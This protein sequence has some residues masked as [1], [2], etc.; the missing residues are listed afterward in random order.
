MVLYV[1]SL[2]D[3]PEI[4]FYDDVKNIYEKLPFDLTLLPWEIDKTLENGFAY[5]F[6]Q[7]I[8]N[9]YKLNEVFGKMIEIKDSGLLGSFEIDYSVPFDYEI[10]V[11][12]RKRNTVLK[13]IEGDLITKKITF[14]KEGNW[15]IN[16]NVDSNGIYTITTKEKWS[17]KNMFL[18]ILTFSTKKSQT[19]NVFNLFPKLEEYDSS[20]NAVGIDI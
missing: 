4:C 15:L 19:S 1:V 8:Q 9:F 20:I 13:V 6:L 5:E 10:E 17:L 11:N 3:I 18:P 14:D 7:C 16:I 12:Y 2:P